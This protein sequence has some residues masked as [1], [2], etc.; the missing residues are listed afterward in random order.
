M[1]NNNKCEKCDRKV[2]RSYGGHNFCELHYLEMN[3]ER[4]AI[5]VLR[6]MRDTPPWK[7]KD[8]IVMLRALRKYLPLER[9]EEC[10]KNVRWYVRLKEVDKN[11]LQK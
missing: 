4:N 9:I 2:T 1:T 8:K 7:I 5:W 10:L 3:P 11:A 6:Y